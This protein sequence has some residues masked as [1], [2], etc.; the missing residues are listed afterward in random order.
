[1]RRSSSFNF[2]ESMV[3]MISR[4][5]SGPPSGSKGQSV[6]KSTCSAPKKSRPQRVAEA[7]PFTEVSA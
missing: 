5:K 3:L 6:P 1:L 7:E 2:S 4:T